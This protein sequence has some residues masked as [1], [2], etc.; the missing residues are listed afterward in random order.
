MKTACNKRGGRGEE[1]GVTWWRVEWAKLLMNSTKTEHTTNMD[2]IESN[3][4]LW[5]L[6]IY[7]TSILFHRYCML[8]VLHC[9][10]CFILV[11]FTNSALNTS[12]QMGYMLFLSSC[13]FL[14]ALV[15]ICVGCVRGKS[16]VRNANDLH[17]SPWQHYWIWK[18]L[19]LIA[20]LRIADVLHTFNESISKLYAFF[21]LSLLP[22][23]PSP[24]P[25][26]N[27]HSIYFFPLGTTLYIPCQD[28]SLK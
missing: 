9:G 24:R 26:P 22:H 5:T 2:A 12:A 20:V 13:L 19:L 3:C 21:S 16:H 25:P 4:Y 15:S 18:W 1:E 14:R 8:L 17:V 23:P 10:E 11:S 6:V 27:L 28:D 7:F